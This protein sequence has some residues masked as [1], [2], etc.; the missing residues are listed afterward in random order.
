VTAT[1]GGSPA[2]QFNIVGSLRNDG[3]YTTASVTYDVPSNTTQ[4]SIVEPFDITDA[5]GEI[6]G[7]TAGDIKYIPE[8]FGATLDF[9]E[10]VP[11][12]L[13]NSTFTEDF[14]ILLGYKFTIDGTDSATNKIYIQDTVVSGSPPAGDIYNIFTNYATGSPADTLVTIYESGINNGTY[15]IIGVTQ[16]PGVHTI[17]EVAAGSPALEDSGIFAGSPAI[18]G[19][20]LRYKE[21]Y[22][23]YITNIVGSP[24]A[25][26]VAGDATANIADTDSIQHI[27]TNA[28]YTV[29]GAPVYDGT[30]TT[31]TV[32]ETIVTVA[33]SPPVDVTV[34]EW[35]GSPPALVPFDDWIISI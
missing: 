26:I 32:V 34:G 12:Q 11:Q 19:G 30:N 16:D 35:V 9:C 23:Y 8:G 22:Q 10:I 21:W 28:I 17:L 5:S 2:Q 14:E 20:V 1:Y 18:N 4:I 25:F 7:F 6:H 27:F 31:I 15:T 29:S 13:T 33:G 3:S 24:N